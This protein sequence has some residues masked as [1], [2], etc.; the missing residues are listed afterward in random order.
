MH[1][2]AG[3]HGQ[4]GLPSVS[5]LRTISCSAMRFLL[6]RCPCH[7]RQPW[8]FGRIYFFKSPGRGDRK[9]RKVMSISFTN[10]HQHIGLNRVGA[11]YKTVPEKGPTPPPNPLPQ[12]EGEPKTEPWRRWTGIVGADARRLSWK[13]RKRGIR[14]LLKQIEIRIA[15]WRNLPN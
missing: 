3:L 4:A 10:S 2:A 1:F 14:R 5:G 7:T 9:R 6:P 11:Y 13:Q 8:D 12:G 15:A